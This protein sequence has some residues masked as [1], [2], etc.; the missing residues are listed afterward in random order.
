MVDQRKLL[1]AQKRLMHERADGFRKRTDKESR[2]L[3]EEVAAAVR[4]GYERRLATKS[5]ATGD[6]LRGVG[7]KWV[8]EGTIAVFNRT[9][10]AV[11]VEFGTGPLGE[12]RRFRR[13][14]PP[15]ALYTWVKRILRVPAKLVPRVA[16]LVARKIGRVG[17][18]PFPALRRSMLDART[19]FPQMARNIGT[20]GVRA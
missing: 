19:R 4:S 8:D 11:H 1:E 15:A 5:G 14:P 10:H 2:M 3:L 13:M 6:L 12:A 17:T 18:R 20:W 16:W 7:Q 9:A